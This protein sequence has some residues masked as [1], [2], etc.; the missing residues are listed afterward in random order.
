MEPEANERLQVPAGMPEDI[1]VWQLSNVLCCGLYGGAVISQHNRVYRRFTAFPWGAELHPSLSLPY[2]G[3]KLATL[4]KAI[5]LV[6]PSAEGNYYHWITDLLPRL[7][8]VQKCGILA[9]EERSI[10]LHKFEARYESD[11]LKIINIPAAKII[12]IHTFAFLEVKDLVITDL[13]SRGRTFPAWK[14]QLLD[15]F[16]E[17]ALKTAGRQFLGKLYLL[18]GNQSKRRLIGEERLVEHLESLGFQILDPRQLT[19]GEQVQAMAGAQVVIGLHGAALTNVI[20]C[21]PGTC[22]IELRSQ[23]QP[24]EHYSE[25]ARTCGLHFESVHLPPQRV[26]KHKHLSNKQHLI[27]TD[28][29]IQELSEKL[30]SLQYSNA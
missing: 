20:F 2:L 7:L 30:S 11:T 12:R 16:R 23:H 22:I 3:R 19:V 18:R 27:L 13:L 5:F 10:I 6:T 26:N 1:S 21:R 29:S 15:E 17:R 14:K 8:L 24:P 28:K 25:I 4:E 9:G